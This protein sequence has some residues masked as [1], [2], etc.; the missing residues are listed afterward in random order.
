M[1]LVFAIILGTLFGYVLYRVG[2]TDA[3]KIISM[4]TLKDMY[5]AKAIASGIGLAALLLFV[6]LSCGLIDPTHLSTKSMFLGVVPGGI[7]LG[8]GWAL[9]GMCP[10]TGVA[11]LGA[12][13]ID[14]LVYVVGG[15]VGA[16]AFTMDYESLAALG[17]F[18]AIWGGK[19]TLASLLN[20]HWAGI[21]LGAAFIL[22]ASLLP[23]RIRSQS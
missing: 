8:I 1:S 10:G 13:R 4:L 22:C 2:A 20:S 19:I 7:L 9:S 21:L 16:A 18:D 11:N 6:G 5:L 15:L 3:D 23:L 17:L 14:A 12:G